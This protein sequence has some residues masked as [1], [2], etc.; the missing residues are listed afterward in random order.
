MAAPQ[1]I[2]PGDDL[3]ASQLRQL[4]RRESRKGERGAKLCA[5]IERSLGAPEGFRVLYERASFMKLADEQAIR[6]PQ[7][8]TV[9]DLTQ[10]KHVAAQIGFP[11]VLKADGSSGGEGV[12]TVHNDR[13]AESGYRELV[14]PVRMLR[15]V[16]R[17]LM[18]H[19]SSLLWPSLLRRRPSVSAQTFVAGREATSTVACWNGV[20]LA[21]LHFEVIHKRHQQGPATVIRAINHPELSAAVEKMVCCLKLSGIHGFD[22]MLQNGTDHAYLIEVNP[23][24]TQVGHLRMGP[25]HDLPA[26]ITA[27]LSGEELRAAKRITNGEIVVLFPQEWMRDPESEYLHS[28]FHDVPW[29]EPEL[30]QACVQD[31]RK[32]HALSARGG[33]AWRGSLVAAPR[34]LPLTPRIVREGSIAA[35]RESQYE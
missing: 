14:A 35:S 9:A 21:A 32:Q 11:L 34:L 4:H 3:A 30:F 33:R 17:A 1:L 7:T 5:L 16:K 6:V 15:A 27:A 23:R 29:E 2:I 26:A 22:F 25:G 18:D 28:A 20:V 8:R 13:E 31:G 12:R 10:L 24:T 19:D